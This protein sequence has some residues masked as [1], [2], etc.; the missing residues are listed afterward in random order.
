M[1]MFRMAQS[2]LAVFVAA[3]VV[4]AAESPV[5]FPPDPQQHLE[6]TCFQT[7][8]PWS[9]I[10][11]LR[12][13]VVLAYGIGPSLP[14]RIQTWRD[15]GYRIH[16]MTGVSWGAYQDYLYGR[17]DG[18]NHEDE[19][20][21]DRAG[22]KDQPRGRCILHVPGDELRKIPLPGH[23]ARAR[24]RR[25]GDPPRRARVLGAERLFGGLQARVAQLLWRGVAAA[26]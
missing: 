21:T 23:P 7:G 10:A 25:R 8:A 26:A 5:A 15:H 1:S 18:V 24:R 19:A 2:L 20:Q 13:D 9:G 12:S 16:V 4:L 6:R 3:T 17:F 11:D 14:Q 22:N